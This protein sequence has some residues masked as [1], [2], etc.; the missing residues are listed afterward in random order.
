MKRFK[1]ELPDSILACKLLYSC[2]LT[3]NERQ[4]VFSASNELNL[5]QL[6]LQLGSSSS[7]GVQLKDE[8]AFV[9]NEERNEES[10]L[11]SGRFQRRGRFRGRGQASSSFLK[12]YRKKVATLLTKKI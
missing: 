11:I 2:D 6:L 9:A 3:C 10:A 4:L 1:M 8:S 12:A 7:S 5:L